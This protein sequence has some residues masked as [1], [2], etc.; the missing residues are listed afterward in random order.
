MTQHRR[1]LI[2]EQ[3]KLYLIS[4]IY[5]NKFIFQVFL[6]TYPWHEAFYK[7]L[8]HV[9]ELISY[10][11]QDELFRF[12]QASHTAKVPES[13]NCFFYL[14]PTLLFVDFCPILSKVVLT[15]YE[16]EWEIWFGL[17]LGWDTAQI[18]DFCTPLFLHR[19]SRKF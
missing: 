19:I 11:S 6:S 5:F 1:N 3:T 9:T 17:C 7:I 16:P 2:T 8:N 4:K 13:G 18:Y 12:L 14:G 15:H 10:H